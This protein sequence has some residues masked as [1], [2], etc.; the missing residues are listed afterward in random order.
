[1]VHDDPGIANLNQRHTPETQQSADRRHEMVLETNPKLNGV[2]ARHAAE[3]SSSAQVPPQA[4]VLLAPPECA[5]DKQFVSHITQLVN[6][7]YAVEEKEFWRQQAG[8]TRTTAPDVEQWI[9]DGELA[10]AFRPEASSSIYVGAPTDLDGVLGCGHMSLAPGSSVAGFGAMACRPSSRGLG[11]GRALL[12]FAEEWAK[13]RVATEMQLEV[14]S[15]DGSWEHPMKTRL[16]AWYE[17]AG[18][19]T[20]RWGSVEVELPHLASMIARPSRVRVLRKV[21]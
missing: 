13:E 3:H 5:S 20:V 2:D 19:V 16:A 17:R 8:F 14:L 21:L 10:I 11:I 4:T 9:R 7:V 12:G 1:V 15:P 18:Y 6:S